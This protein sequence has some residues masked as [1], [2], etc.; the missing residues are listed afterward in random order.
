MRPFPVLLVCLAV[1]AAAPTALAGQAPQESQPII[2]VPREEWESMKAKLEQLQR[3]LDELKKAARPAEAAPP[4]Q[5]PEQESLTEEPGYE[6]PPQPRPPERVQLELPDISVIGDVR[7]NW[8]NDRDDPNRK[9]VR[10]Y[11]AE[12]AL[13]SYLYPDIRGD[14]IL[15]V[16]RHG[17]E[18][19]VHVEEGF[20][21][22]LDIGKGFGLLAGRKFVPFGKANQIHTHHR[23]YSDTPAVLT[24]FFGERLVGDGA[25]VSYLVPTRQF[26]KLEL[27]SWHAAAHSHDPHEQDGHE[28]EAAGL[29]LLN[30]VNTGRLWTSRP[31]SDISELECGLSHAT[32]SGVRA[33][34]LDL[35]YKRWPTAYKRL[36]VQ[37]E[38]LRGNNENT[39]DRIRGHYI[40]VNQRLDKY[41]DVGL[42]YD[43]S[44]L[45]QPRDSHYSGLAAIVTR[46]LTE[47]TY[48]R[49]Q[50][51]QGHLP[52][53]GTLREPMVVMNFG[54]GPHAHPLE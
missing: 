20:I 39:G 48:L 44:E 2:A 49:L 10:L 31:L 8:T 11:H 16:A 36:T 40:L 45:V 7:G 52:G 35:T 3:E 32:A 5:P 12:L 42:R 6:A 26:L 18:F 46:H 4:A 9:K 37:A 43:W 54:M 25:V 30:T 41:W 14:V 22:F 50:Y 13:Q 19:D 28:H 38:Y 17:D 29:G 21:N 33:T 1:A 15:G 51:K 27:G 23:L 47:T 34:G 53:G 24:S